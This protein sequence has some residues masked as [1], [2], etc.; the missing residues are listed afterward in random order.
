[1]AAAL[2]ERC[3]AGVGVSILLDAVGSSRM[4]R[5][6]RDALRASGCHLAF[7]HSLNL[8]ALK[9]VKHRNHRR[10]LVVDGRVGFTGGT[11]I[12]EK[13]TGNGRHSRHWRQTDVRV[14]GPIVRHL[15]AAFAENWRD[16]TGMLL[17][18]DAYFPP[19]ERRGDW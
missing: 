16:T 15:Q 17:G 4:P 6:Q 18:D 7:Y 11:G 12:G 13:W 2:A 19:V 10:I 5:G 3:R 14:E 1:M 9:R 8:L